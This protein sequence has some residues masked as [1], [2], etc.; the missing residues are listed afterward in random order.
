MVGHFSEGSMEYWLA[1]QHKKRQNNSVN[2]FCGWSKALQEDGNDMY[3]TEGLAL[4]CA[5]HSFHSMK[6]FWVN[7]WLQFQFLTRLN[8]VLNYLNRNTKIPP[9]KAILRVPWIYQCSKLPPSRS[10]WELLLQCCYLSSFNVEMLFRTGKSIFDV[11]IEHVFLY[12]LK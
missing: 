1:S 10:L 5:H 9:R 7:C 2:L 8:L 4:L 12:S 3:A 6:F 11:R